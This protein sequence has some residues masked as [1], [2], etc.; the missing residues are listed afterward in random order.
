MGKIETL[1]PM[2]L[3]E[4]EKILSVAVVIG[5]GAEECFRTGGVGEL[6]QG[7]KESPA[8][9]RI[10]IMDF[11]YEDVLESVLEDMR[12]R[13]AV[14]APLVDFLVLRGDDERRLEGLLAKEK[15]VGE[16]F[17][18]NK[19]GEL[20][21]TKPGK[22]GIQNISRE[23]C[24]PLQESSEMKY[25]VVYHDITDIL[26]KV[27]G[28]EG[29]FIH[30]IKDEPDRFVL[31]FNNMKYYKLGGLEPDNDEKL[32]AYSS[33]RNISFGACQYL[34]IAQES[35]ADVL[36]NCSMRWTDYKLVLE[37]SRPFRIGNGKVTTM[38]N[39]FLPSGRYLSSFWFNGVDTTGKSKIMDNRAY[40]KTL[41]GR[42]WY[43]IHYNGKVE[44]ERFEPAGF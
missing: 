28:I 4:L 6:Y 33:F 13:Y 19:E 34:L 15:R 1:R 42:Q 16:T 38:Y 22:P 14:S 21:F 41:H 39:F 36:I 31:D 2:G 43:H 3:K 25:S 9:F 5:E 35:R 17:S 37:V 26:M 20:I 32:P 7:S 10:K 27:T 11:L 23:D 44:R 18:L 29:V 8:R 24:E 40:V 30:E 12:R